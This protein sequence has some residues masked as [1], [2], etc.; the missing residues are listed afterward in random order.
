MKY[1]DRHPDKKYLSSFDLIGEE[2]IQALIT[3]FRME[4]IERSGSDTPKP[5]LE[6]FG[7]KPIVLNLTNDKML[8]RLL[9]TNDS[10]KWIGKVIIVGVDPVKAFGEETFGLRIRRRLGTPEGYLRES[11][12]KEELKSRYRALNDSSLLEL[13]KQIAQEKWKK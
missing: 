9:R 8:V 5:V 13:T 6:L 7:L 12:S 11:A 4:V 10:N 1:T 3:G 2:N